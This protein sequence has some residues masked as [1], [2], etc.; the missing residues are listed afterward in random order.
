MRDAKTILLIADGEA[1]KL[2]SGFLKLCCIQGQPMRKVLLAFALLTLCSGSFAQEKTKVVPDGTEG[3]VLPVADSIGTKKKDRWR[4]F[5]GRFT[6]FKFG[7]GFLYEYAGYKQDE[8]AKEQMDSAGTPLDAAFKMRD[9][10]L[11]ASGQLKTKRTI[12]W[13]V[14][15]MYDAVGDEWLVRESGVMIAVPEIWGHLFIGRTKEGFSMN[16]VMNG[17][18]GW[19]MERQIALDVIPILAD[20]IKW[21]GFLPKQRIFWNTGIYADW[22][23]RGQGFS[24]FEWQFA[25]RGGWLPVYEPE[26]KKI[27]HIGAS[28]RYGVPLDG[29]I[30]IRSRPEANPAPFFIETKK[31]STSHSNQY[32]AELYYTNGPFMAGSEIYAHGFSSSTAGSPVF[33]GGD[34]ALTYVFTGES[35]PYSTVSGI[36]GFVPVKRSL[37]RG[38]PGAWEAVLRYSRLDLSDAAIDGGKFWRITPMINWYMSKELRLEL[39][40]GYGKLERF[41]LKGATQF[42]QARIQFA[43][44]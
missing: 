23:S 33:R 5:N 27:L 8:A 20:G 4:L 25:L 7:M 3:E 12:T 13:K 11:L 24:T 28:Y 36:Y 22:F 15:L 37:F 42:F 31:F 39:G 34:V 29:Q 17:Y 16:K 40:Y 6:T 10:R 9:F 19:T 18:A 21:M 41:N 43:L 26:E 38:G 44:L 30:N 2:Q 35:R 14:G 1:N 32:G